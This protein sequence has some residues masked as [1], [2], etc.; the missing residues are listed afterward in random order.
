MNSGNPREMLE[1]N[2]PKPIN[3]FTLNFWIKIDTF[4]FKNGL[5]RH[6]L[7]R[8]DDFNNK[9]FCSWDQIE[10]INQSLG[11]WLHPDDNSIRLCYKADNNLNYIDINDIPIKMSF[12]IT[13]VVEQNSFNVYTNGKLVESIISNANIVTRGNMFLFKPYSF[14]GNIEDFIFYNEP[15]SYDGAITL[16]R[17]KKIKL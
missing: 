12:C 8:G 5:W 16:C 7:H 3:G 14:V 17:R 15:V 2:L 13:I 11:I 6:I 10:K 1:K 4:F 9:K